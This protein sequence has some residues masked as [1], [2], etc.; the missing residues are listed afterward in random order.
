MST[1]YENNAGPSRSP[2][3]S[4]DGDDEEDEDSLG[5]END[6]QSYPS[7]RAKTQAAS[8]P[9]ISS[10]PDGPR[11]GDSHV[12]HRAER[13]EQ[14]KARSAYRD[15]SSPADRFRRTVHRV[16]AMHRTSRAMTLGSVGAEPGIDP[17]RFS[18][19]QT[20]GNIRQKC[21]IE[22]TDYSPLRMG[23][24]RMTNG[25][26]LN[27]L[28]DEKSYTRAPW[29]KVRWIN[30][31]GISWDV[32]S[33]IA[34]KYDM[35]PLAL[36]DVLHQRGQAR[37]KADY[38]PQHLFLRIL[39]HM[40]GAAP[41]EVPAALVPGSTP[42]TWSTGRTFTNSRRPTTAWARSSQ[43]GGEDDEDNKYNDDD[44]TQSTASFNPA[45]GVHRSSSL[46]TKRRRAAAVATLE[47][48]K[49]EDRVHVR[50]QPVCMLLYRDG[51]VITFHPDSTLEFSAPIAARLR[52]RDTSLRTSADAS[53]LVESLLDLVVDRALEVIDEY[54]AKLHELERSVLIRRKLKTVR[55]LHI[56]SGDLTLYKRTLSPIKTLLYGL[57]RY[58]EDRCVALLDPEK[59]RGTKV[60]GFMSARSKVYLA[61]VIDHM[62]LVLSNVNMFAAMTENLINYSFN[63]A[64]RDTNLVMRRLTTISVICL[65]L[66][67]LT[68]YCGM[69]FTRQWTIRPLD[70]SDVIFWIIALPMLAI[71]IPIF[72]YKDAI[73]TVQYI[74][75]RMVAHTVQKVMFCR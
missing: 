74:K 8:P 57:R 4:E 68:G 49:K 3:C 72:L 56:M 21:L 55:S 40:V 24:L 30:V 52:Q 71:L 1:I 18:S 70:H 59:D 65:P 23:S 5:E 41:E 69:N 44:T 75:S 62:D 29:V 50:V 10:P 7:Q 45:V 39:S 25:E 35:H 46:L 12:S 9:P 32:M 42:A 64:S 33:A 61:D 28:E 31:G 60:V 34:L 43:S 17:R 27:F 20:Y 38:Y 37:S 2:R 47:Q 51:T 63:M 66:T 14:L 54:Q 26:F 48:L 22:V 19:Q 6:V 11:S 73:R 36:E 67:F 58:D 13:D 15:G 16:M 53:L